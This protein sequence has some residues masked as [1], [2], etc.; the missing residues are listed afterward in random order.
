MSASFYSHANGI[1]SRGG[2]EG[3][4]CTYEVS[5]QFVAVM[6]FLKA[7]PKDLSAS[8]LYVEA[9][10]KLENET[11]IRTRDDCD[12]KNPIRWDEET[13]SYGVDL[14]LWLR[15]TEEERAALRAALLSEI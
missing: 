5:S 1:G 7:D 14:Q 12:F 2:A 4:V 9:V 10:A 3:T 15:L 6:D 13:Q 11:D 8:Q